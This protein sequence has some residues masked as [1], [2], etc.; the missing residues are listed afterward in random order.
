[1]TS[2]PCRGRPPAARPPTNAP[3]APVSE[4]PRVDAPPSSRPN[5]G[6]IK[7]FFITMSIALTA[8]TLLGL[9]IAFTSKRDRMLHVV[10]LVAGTLVPIV[11]SML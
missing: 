6:P 3:S 10:L 5:T 7:A 8:S 9:Y 4:P 11:L 1:M 2:P